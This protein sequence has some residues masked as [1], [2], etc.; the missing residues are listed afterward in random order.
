MPIFMNYKTTN[1]KQGAVAC[2]NNLPVQLGAQSVAFGNL[3]GAWIS[4]NGGVGDAITW[5]WNKGGDGAAPQTWT[6]TDGG[7]KQAPP[8]N[9]L[10]Q[11][12]QMAAQLRPYMAPMGKI[13]VQ[14][15]STQQAAI[16]FCNQA[17]IPTS[18]LK[19]PTN[20]LVS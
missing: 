3:E 11:L 17:K 16:S 20:S 10:Q 12:E 8:S 14:G 2:T 4:W 13:S 19:L 7:D 6:W 1:G 15:V 5:T 9:L 18:M